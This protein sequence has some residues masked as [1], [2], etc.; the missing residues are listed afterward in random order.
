MT[1][2][3]CRPLLRRLSLFCCLPLP[4]GRRRAVTMKICSMPRAN[5]DIDRAADLDAGRDCDHHA[6]EREPEGGRANNS[7]SLAPNPLALQH[8]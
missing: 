2:I 6:Q 7:G 1:P 8:H 3:A 4:V 5:G